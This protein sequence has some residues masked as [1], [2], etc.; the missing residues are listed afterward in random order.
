MSIIILTWNCIW[1][2]ITYIMTTMNW[3]PGIS[4]YNQ[5]III[6]LVKEIWICNTNSLTWRK[7][8]SMNLRRILDMICV[9]KIFIFKE[10]WKI[11]NKTKKFF[12]NS[13]CSNNNNCRK[14]T[15]LLLLVTLLWMKNMNT[16][17]LKTVWINY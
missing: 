13:I 2:K 14:E 17:H 15:V 11:M 10:I 16:F 1:K 8:L 9:I 6:I 4:T 12:K 7:I 3:I 5:L